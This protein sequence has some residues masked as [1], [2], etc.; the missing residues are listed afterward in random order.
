MILI[1]LILSL[2]KYWTFTFI[3]QNDWYSARNNYGRGNRTRYTF[4]SFGSK[5]IKYYFI[6]C[7]RHQVYIYGFLWWPFQFVI[8]IVLFAIYPLVLHILLLKIIFWWNF[9]MMCFIIAC[10]LNIIWI[11]KLGIIMDTNTNFILSAPFS[12]WVICTYSRIA[13]INKQVF[14]DFGIPA[15]IYD[16]FWIIY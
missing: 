16:Y 4:F 14:V 12:K 15:N 2:V 13:C 9:F 1:N 10:I 5:L 8:N 11:F 6:L 7:R 3:I